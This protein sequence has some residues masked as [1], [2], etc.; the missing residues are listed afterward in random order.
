MAK[1]IGSSKATMTVRQPWTVESLWEAGVHIMG[2]RT[3]YDMAAYWPASSEPFAAPMNKIPKVVFSR[4]GVETG[5]RKRDLTTRALTDAIRFRSAAEAQPTSATATK[6][7]AWSESRIANGDLGEEI[8]RLKKE[9]GKD[10]LA[11]GG[12]R[13]AQSLVALGLI[14]EY[15]LLVQPVALG[16]GLPLF[17]G[18]LKPIDLKLVRTT[19]FGARTVAHIYQP[20]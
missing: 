6:G 3:F 13:F 10:I 1:S 7:A 15:R 5:G 17:A 9:S 2:S 4:T 19:A 16:K 14:D 12:A 20:L 11:H 8:A 18:L